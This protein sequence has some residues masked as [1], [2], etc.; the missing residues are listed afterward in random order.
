MM[1]SRLFDLGKEK[2]KVRSDIAYCDLDWEE[3]EEP[4]L[5]GGSQ[6]RNHD[7]AAVVW[8]VSRD[9]DGEGS[10]RSSADPIGAAPICLPP[11]TPT[12]LKTSVICRRSGAFSRQELREAQL[13]APFRERMRFFPSSQSDQDGRDPGRHRP[14]GCRSPKSHRGEGCNS[15]R[16]SRDVPRL[17]SSDSQVP[18]QDHQ[19]QDRRREIQTG[20]RTR[21]RKNSHPSNRDHVLGALAQRGILVENTQEAP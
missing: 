10:T 18:A 15:R 1:A 5:T 4:R 11:I 19:D 17:P 14:A 16:A 6:S 3:L 9:Q 7:L 13:E 12:W 8:T 2:F 20:P 21:Q